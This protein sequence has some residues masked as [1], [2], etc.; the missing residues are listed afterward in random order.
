MGAKMSAG[1]TTISA[2]VRYIF[3]EPNS[4]D[5]KGEKVRHDPAGAFRSPFPFSG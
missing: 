5:L 4:K 3:L 2:D 1:A